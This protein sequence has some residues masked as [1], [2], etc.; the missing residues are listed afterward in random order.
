M[1]YIKYKE[2]KFPKSLLL[3]TSDIREKDASVYDLSTDKIKLE[4]Y[5]TAADE[6]TFLL[7]V[8]FLYNFY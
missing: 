2:F 1:I 8:Y 7:K 4:K 5:L 3:D 6:S